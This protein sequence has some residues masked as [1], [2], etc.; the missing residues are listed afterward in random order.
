[1]AKINIKTSQ[2][3]VPMCYAYTTPQI[4][5]NDG[6]IKI[7]YTERDVETRVNEQTH[8]LGISA[9]IEWRA[10]AIYDDGT[11]DAF[12]DKD[13]HAYL[14]KD[15]VAR[16]PNT[17]WFYMSPSVSENKFDR[18]KKNRGILKTVGVIP[19]KLR[20]E[21]QQAVEQARK[22]F[23]AKK[24]DEPEFLWNAKPRFG[25]TLSTYDL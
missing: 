19:Y 25:K 9:K 4:R 13:F 22:Y 3:V 21:Q 12:T 8:I 1:M 20:D 2:K 23:E 17:E 5:E 18:F 14:K 16:K 24:G 11:G 15:G 7:G 6:W 10:T